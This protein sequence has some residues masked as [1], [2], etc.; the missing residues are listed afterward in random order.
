MRNLFYILSFCI[1]SLSMAGCSTFNL[2]GERTYISSS[3]YKGGYWGKWDTEYSLKTEG[4]F[5]ANGFTVLL[6]NNTDHPS[7]F[8]TRV[9]ANEFVKKAGDWFEYTGKVELN[10]SDEYI[11]GLNEFYTTKVNLYEIKEKRITF[12]CIIRISKPIKDIFKKHGTINIFY[13]GV[14]R[15]YSF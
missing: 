3:I 9:T 1:F 4:N 7:D 6:Y 5:T 14:G 10:V 13:N 15:G 12:P 2:T 11:D 8:E